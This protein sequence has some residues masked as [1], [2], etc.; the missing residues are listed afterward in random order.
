MRGQSQGSSSKKEDSR[1]VNRSSIDG[2]SQVSSP[3]SNS[4][5]AN[6]SILP[7]TSSPL[8]VV[9]PKR[10]RPRQVSE[11][12]SS[13]ARS[14]PSSM[15]Q[16]PKSEISS[17]NL[18]KILGSAAENGYDMGNLVNSQGVAA[19]P[20]EPILP[21]AMKVGSESKP[22]AEE[23]RES[24]DLSH[25][26][27]GELTREEG[28]SSTYN[29]IICANVDAKTTNESLLSSF[30]S[31]WDCMLPGPPSKNNGGA[32]DISN[33]GLL[34]YAARS[35]VTIVDVNSIQLVFTL[36]LP[37]YPF[38]AGTT[39]AASLS[40]FITAEASSAYCSYSSTDHQH[41]PLPLR[42][43]FPTRLFSAAPLVTRRGNQIIKRITVLKLRTRRGND[44]V[45]VH[46]THPKSTATL[47]YSHGNAAD[48]GQIK[49]MASVDLGNR[50]LF[51]DEYGCTSVSACGYFK[52]NCIYFAQDNLGFSVL[53]QQEQN[54]TVHLEDENRKL[55]EQL[56][57]HKVMVENANGE[58]G[59]LSA[60]VEQEKTKY[61]NTKEK[62]S[63]A[64]W[65]R[66]L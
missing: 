49:W 53:P 59:R 36:P 64:G 5:S 26:R 11:N 40:P 35:P 29:S 17:P 62:L 58:I 25:E 42:G 37:P 44:I 33:A 34:A 65:E 43:L 12:P 38:S 6:N 56:D 45:A 21:E 23:L 24:R 54:M 1:E 47:L 41:N 19:Q 13:I 10:K 28:A 60:E 30:M 46:V 51:I 27:G 32:A 50:L 31:Y 39:V 48:L 20:P 7:T 66:R 3:M 9:A 61:S 8:S 22:V 15:D 2:K 4:T 16:K 55:V 57:E 18:E 14:S 52:P 63:L